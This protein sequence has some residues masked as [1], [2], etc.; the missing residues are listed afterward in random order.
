ME[1]AVKSHLLHLIDEEIENVMSEIRE[2]DRQ[3]EEKQNRLRLL[4]Q[5]RS[6]IQE[7]K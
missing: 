3:Y 6:D 1:D 2:L 4:R 7:M 5:K